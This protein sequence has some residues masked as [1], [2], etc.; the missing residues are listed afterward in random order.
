MSV[1]YGL[2]FVSGNPIQIDTIV[3]VNR[4]GRKSGMFFEVDRAFAIKGNG[5]LR[6]GGGRGEERAARA[7]HSAGHGRARW[8]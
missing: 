8:R 7:A 3:S 1:V 5:A 2:R 4:G 6:R